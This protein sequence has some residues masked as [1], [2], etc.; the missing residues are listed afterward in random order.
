M[1]ALTLLFCLYLGKQFHGLVLLGMS[2]VCNFTPDFEKG[3][4]VVFVL[5]DEA[6]LIGSFPINSSTEES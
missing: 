2:V 3:V 5:R 1:P 6:Q 4:A